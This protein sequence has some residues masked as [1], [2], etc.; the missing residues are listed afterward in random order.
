MSN[1][2]IDNW[3]AA[4]DAM[5]AR[6]KQLLRYAT[7][8]GIGMAGNIQIEL[9]ELE[10]AIQELEKKINTYEN[11]PSVKNTTNDTALAATVE[12]EIEALKTQIERLS[13]QLKISNNPPTRKIIK[14]FL[15]SSYELKAERE[16]F[17]LQF[18]ARKRKLF[19][20]DIEVEVWE[21]AID[22]MSQTRLQDEYNRTI[23][24]CDI[25]VMLLFSKVGKFTSEEFETAFGQFKE[26]GKPLVYTYFKDAPI[27]TG[28]LNR[29]DVLSLLDFQEKL[30]T[31][32]HFFT[33]FK[34]ATDLNFQFSNQLDKLFPF[35]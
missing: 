34:D 17:E 26:H 29:A 24:E 30:K 10:D 28:S 20:H 2:T 25:F 4:L 5:Y 16:A 1:K 31:L 21:D 3:K 13:A 9:E 15:A 18:G 6:H 27:N 23:K 14:I 12:N 33:P 19:E 7:Q 32:G 35:G 11:T 22:A 8:A